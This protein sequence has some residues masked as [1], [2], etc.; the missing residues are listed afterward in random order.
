MEEQRK[1][2]SFQDLD[3]YQS[4]YKAMQL[5]FEHILRKLSK[6]EDYDLKDQIRR[7]VKAIPRLIAEGHAKRHQRKGFQ[8][9]IDDA[10]TE[11]NE[12]IVSLCQARDLYP[13]DIDQGICSALIDTY[14][15]ASRQLFKLALAW[16]KFETRRRKTCDDSSSVTK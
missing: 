13:K 12:T 16:D 3:V 6:E 7:S 11:S 8:R 2:R 4:T 15:K 1:V 14:D 10:M 5:V 9:Y